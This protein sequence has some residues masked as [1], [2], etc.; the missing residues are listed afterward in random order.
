M[1]LDVLSKIISGLSEVAMSLLLI[2]LATGWT[3]S[4]QSLDI[5][6]GLEIYLPMTALIVMVQIIVAALPFVDVDASHKYHDFAGVQGWVL[7]VLKLIVYAYYL[8]C[9][10]ETRKKADKKQRMYLDTLFKLSSSYLLA[11][12]ATIFICFMFEPY[13]RQYMFTLFS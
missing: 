3:L 1:V 10:Y 6:D 8:W 4:Y 2:L 5:D 13:E 12:P 7:F 11:I 9:I